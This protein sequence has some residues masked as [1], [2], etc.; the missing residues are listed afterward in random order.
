MSFV[1]SFEDAQFEAREGETVLDVLLRS[2]VDAAYSCKGGS[3]QTCM[4]QCQVGAV[5]EV[6]TRGLPE[7]LRRLRYFLPCR[8]EVHSNMALRKPMPDD[9]V[10]SCIL[11]E[12]TPAENGD[13]TLLFE[14]MRT[15]R[16]RTGQTLQIVFEDHEE[17]LVEL[18]SDPDKDYLPIVK[19][20]ADQLSRLPADLQGEPEFGVEFQVRGPFDGERPAEL[21]YPTPDPAL[22]QA[23]DD[24]LLARRVLEAFYDRVYEDE[25]LSPFFKGVTKDRAIDKQYSFMRQCITGEKIYMGDRPRNAHHWMIITHEVFDHRQ[26]LMVETMRSVGLGDDI[27]ERWTGFEEYFRPDIVKSNIWPRKV[28]NTLVMNHGFSSEVIAEATICDHCQR[29]VLAGETVLLHQ[30]RGTISCSDCASQTD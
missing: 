12:L 9:L 30:R 26:Q 29:E 25:V 4:L 11:C 10:T 19:L 20:A 7:N 16:Y 6:A 5:S 8:C 17:A 22:W 24:G 23:L 18:I 3:C 15:L 2:G 28:G 14:P 1:V 21:P 13:K 27:I